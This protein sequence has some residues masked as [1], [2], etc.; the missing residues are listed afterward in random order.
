MLSYVKP[1]ESK[2]KPFL[3]EALLAEV[4]LGNICNM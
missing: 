4:V 1:I 2:F 3:K